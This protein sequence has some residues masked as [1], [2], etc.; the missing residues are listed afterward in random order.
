MDGI[1]STDPFLWDVGQVVNELCHL[2]RP[3]TRNPEMLAAKLLENEV[4][5]Y[6]LLTYDLVASANSHDLRNELFRTLNVQLA[7]HKNALGEAIM[8][9]R[10]RSPE[11]RHWKLDNLENDGHEEP[12]V[13]SRGL[14]GLY[15]AQMTPQ[16]ELFLPWT[17]PRNEPDK[18][19]SSTSLPRQTV[20]QGFSLR[21]AGPDKLGTDSD[22]IHDTDVGAAPTMES[23][24]RLGELSPVTDA[25]S[26]VKQ[27]KRKRVAPELIREE[28]VHTLAAPIATEAD[29]ISRGSL[30]SYPWDTADA[31]AYLGPGA[32]SSREVKSHSKG[33]TLQI[34]G[35]GDALCTPA[36]T[37]FPPGR[38]LAIN[39]IMR[40]FLVGN[41]RKIAMADAGLTPDSLRQPSTEDDKILDLDDIPDEVDE[42]TQREMDAEKAELDQMTEDLEG[43][44]GSKR[45]SQDRVRQ[46]LDQSVSE[47]VKEW[48]EKKR[49]KYQNKANALWVD[50]SRRGAKRDRILKAR[51]Q[52]KFYDDRIKKLERGILKQTWEN[53]RQV[54]FQARLLEQNIEDKIYQCWLADT[55]ESR[56]PPPKSS[57]MPQR[58]VTH[59]KPRELDLS[60]G[61]ILT[62][63]DEEAFIVYDDEP[64]T[65]ITPVKAARH[66][67]PSR[68][69]RT[70]S[71]ILIDSPDYI[72]LTLIPSSRASSPVQLPTTDVALA[73]LDTPTKVSP[74]CTPE[75]KKE[76]GA[77]ESVQQPPASSWAEK[78]KNIKNIVSFPT[79]HWTK[80]KDRFAL[81]ITLL[82]KLGHLRRSA[83]FEHVRACE[84]HES[85]KVTILRHIS[86]PLKDLDRLRIAS[87]ESLAFDVS[88][89]FLCFLKTKNL[90][91]TRLADLKSSQ[92][93]KLKAKENHS[94]WKIF[95]AFVRE[96]APL[97]PQDNQIYREEAF[98]DDEVLGDDAG[99]DEASLLEQSSKSKIPRKAAPKEIVRNKEAVDLR[100]R[101]IHRQEEQEARRLR[102]RANL[103]ANGQLSSDKSRLIINESK[104]DDQSFIYINDHIGMRI[105]DHQIDGVRFL[106]NQIMQD[107]ELRQGCLLSHSMG[108]GKTMQVIT[109]LVAI[110]E[111]S[112]SSD[113]T[114]VSQIPKDLRQSKTL[115]ACPSGLVNNWM[116]E[117][118]IWDQDRI[119]GELY[120]VDSGYTIEERV[121]AVRKW[122]QTGGVF[123]IGYPMLRQMAGLDEEGS[124]QSMFDEPNIVVADEAHMLKNPTSKLHLVCSRFQA[125]SRIAM[126]GSPLANN[127]EEYYFMINWVA[128]NFLGPVSEF[129]E[130]YSIPIQHGV[131]P[132]SSGVDKRKA[133]KKLA[134]LKQ[135]VAP[136]V[137]RATMMTCMKKDLPQKQ[138]FVICVKPKPLQVKLYNLFAQV[139]RGE[140]ADD[141][142]GEIESQ[143]AIFRLIND[144]GLL[145]NHP[146]A[147]YQKAI[148]SQNPPKTKEKTKG[149]LPP[150][151]TPAVLAEFRGVEAS[152]P[153]LSTK[154]ELL[155]RILD[156]AQRSKD[157]VLV[158]SHSIPTLDYLSKLFQGQNRRFS[159]LDGKTLISK[160]QDEIKK[161]NSD[162]TEFYLI[163]TRAGGVG[164]NIHG[165]NKVVIFDFR[166]N[167][168]H[169]QQAIGRSY[170]IGQTKPVSVY[171]F[172]AAGTFEQDLHG[173]AIFKTQ[174]ATRVVD[175][176]NPV[177]WGN[178]AVDLTH[179]V[180][181]IRKENLTQF[182]GKDSI[183]DKLISY[184]TDNDVIRKIMSTETF[185]EEDVKAPLSAEEQ[186]EAN[187]MAAL[188]AL[189]MT[190]PEEYRRRQ[191]E[192]EDRQIRQLASHLVQGSSFTKDSEMAPEVRRTLQ[193]ATDIS[194]SLVLRNQSQTEP[195]VLPSASPGQIMESAV[196]P[197]S[198][199][200]SGGSTST[201]ALVPMP[202]AYTYFGKDTTEIPQENAQQE[203][204]QSTSVSGSP[205]S[206]AKHAVNPFTSQI[207]N[208][209]KAELKQKLCKK[210]E[211]LPRGSLPRSDTAQLKVVEKLIDS[212]DTIRRDHKF[213]FLPDN[214]H[215]RALGN[216]AE[217]DKFVFA[218]MSGQLEASYLALTDARELEKYISTLD[219]PS[220]GTCTGQGQVEP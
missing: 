118:L 217:Q 33:L 176:K 30:D 160:R 194:P 149:S 143:G 24:S 202:G 136:K 78:Y 102:L 67:I 83:I 51:E 101:E 64:I 45:L 100:E 144:L 29:S 22:R 95:H 148:E 104:Q 211:T 6:T 153:S 92:I 89:T 154:V 120:V 113:Q 191:Q 65:P 167:P 198:T 206:T 141:V 68:L 140:S 180:R 172:V 162:Q 123:V 203:V 134:A 55:L 210:L 69:I 42:E 137:H 178:R 147:L 119:L 165:A 131:E 26:H 166:W 161:F 201:P 23:M 7:R 207:R 57:L 74:D 125:S 38:R 193:S 34:R 145:C 31:F 15:S 86:H 18:A 2:S 16:S 14:D 93:A 59:P 196:L 99:E 36:P 109:L 44:H 188:N 124:L 52:A 197:S 54:R 73:D 110:Q 130:I 41:G 25:S 182:Q 40:R 122:S 98:D 60:D 129:R 219:S 50:A 158:F 200:A 214:Q 170:R 127:I 94:S 139:I 8:K 46:L 204:G 108:L 114:I 216:F 79:S 39:R 43:R 49:P 21:K 17:A 76:P 181:E 72:D 156:D 81:A 186:M 215:W 71:P 171:H 112:K 146:Y 152:C 80:E 47:M 218:V 75:V 151:I 132:G 168:V 105:K 179:N 37:R 85:F 63:S 62:S 177:S 205:N 175:K 28:P 133:L 82:W 19:S 213:G 184:G 88:R 212:I 103:G 117:I 90:K 183:L 106:W 48:T 121:G 111:S 189:R 209:G 142:Q 96:M 116:D 53:E 61:E 87:P 3:C 159:R 128:P 138:E 12:D 32:I 164:L 208:P 155:T 97:F 115:V 11:F 91:E 10:A 9:L 163:S 173:R 66:A 187:D 195:Q 126:T 20:D 174:L 169:E 150:S 84:A 27:L 58:P 13:R 56:F 4:D 135:I 35:E 185:E 190:N 1:Q 70:P 77:D 220:S 5:G 157:K 192:I 199:H 107:P